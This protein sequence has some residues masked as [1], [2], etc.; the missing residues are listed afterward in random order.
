MA[1]GEKPMN[2]RALQGTMIVLG[3]IP[4]TTGILTMFGL[5]DP[6]YASAHLPP[7]ALLDSNLRFFGGTW[8]GLGPAVWRLVPLINCEPEM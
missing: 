8:L 3:A 7:N 6:L 1:K 5:A 4:V 2:I